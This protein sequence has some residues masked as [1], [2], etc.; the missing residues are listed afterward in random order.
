M[1]KILVMGLPGSGKTTFSNK[2]F[3]Y[4]DSYGI[5]VV[6]YNADYIRN[7]FNDWD[8][9]NQGRLRQ[10]LRMTEYAEECQKSDM[11]AICDFV[12]PFRKFRLY[13]EPTIMVWM[14]TI[15]E[16]RYEDTNLLFEPPEDYTYRIQ[17]Y[18]YDDV[19]TDIK[20]RVG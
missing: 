9:S 13:F 15:K 2:L 12:C 8:F 7:K 17:H 18:N 14:D 19:I 20:R 16:S 10:L 1:S 6:Y 5:P 11:I 4:L 3:D